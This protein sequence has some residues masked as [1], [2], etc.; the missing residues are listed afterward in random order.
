[1]SPLDPVL[2]ALV[3]AVV[4]ASLLVTTLGSRETRL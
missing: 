3:I 2:L 4:I 1:V